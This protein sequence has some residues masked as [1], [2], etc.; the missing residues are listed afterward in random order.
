MLVTPLHHRPSGKGWSE[1]AGRWL[2]EEEGERM[3]KKERGRVL[4]S[5][6]WK[7]SAAQCRVGKGMQ[8]VDECWLEAPSPCYPPLCY[9]EGDQQQWWQDSSACLSVHLWSRVG[10]SSPHQKRLPTP[11]LNYQEILKVCNPDPWDVTEA[12]EQNSVFFLSLSQITH[13]C[14]WFL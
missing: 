10:Y 3:R 1:N 7:G 12:T 4:T 9:W 8:H 6:L 13:S 14:K 5:R 11:K 2:L